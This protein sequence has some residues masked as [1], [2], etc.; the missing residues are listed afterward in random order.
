MCARHKP[1][2]DTE[3][4]AATKP[5]LDIERVLNKEPKYFQIA[6]RQVLTD[7][8]VLSASQSLRGDLTSYAACGAGGRAVFLGA[9]VGGR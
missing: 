6:S 8:Q 4:V 9:L 7:Q 3:R 1:V 5:V 2:L